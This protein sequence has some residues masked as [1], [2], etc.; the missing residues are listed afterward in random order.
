LEEKLKE[1]IAKYNDN[2]EKLSSQEIMTDQKKLTELNRE[3]K[4]LQP[5][6]VAAENYLKVLTDYENNKVI[7]RD[8]TQDPEF[9]ELAEEENNKTG[10]RFKNMINTSRS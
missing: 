4:R 8:K 10:R 1:L 6:V 5:I 9:R 2:L 3:Q 7:M